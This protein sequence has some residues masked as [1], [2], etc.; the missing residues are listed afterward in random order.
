MGIENTDN[1][2]RNSGFPEP[3][4]ESREKLEEDEDYRK[5][6]AKTYRWIPDLIEK[7]E[8]KPYSLNFILGPRQVGK[9]TSLKLLT[10]KLLDAGI[11]AERIFYFRCDRISDFRELDEVLSGYLAMRERLGIKNSYILLDEI[12]FPRE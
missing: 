11:G 9:T 2:L 3:L 6:K 10:K 12:T 7:I 8:L 5:W 4:V 1:E